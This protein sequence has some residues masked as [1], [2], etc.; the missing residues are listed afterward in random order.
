MPVDFTGSWVNQ[1]GS[2]LRLQA[3][4]GMITGQFESGVGDDGQR[5]WVEI[6]GRYLDD[7]IT[8]ST[9]YDQFKS[10]VSWVGQH[11]L[12]NQGAG[13]I[14]TQWLHATNIPDDAEIEWLWSS[15]KIG[16]DFFRRA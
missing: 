15:N 1:H 10:V 3:V 14:N 8:F 11:T 16:A 4:G 7:V 12:D 5:L 13:V 9:V 2:Q 6:T